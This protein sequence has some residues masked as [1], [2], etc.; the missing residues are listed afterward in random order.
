MRSLLVV[1]ALI[2]GCTARAHEAPV[3]TGSA[4]GSSIDEPRGATQ[5]PVVA[6]AKGELAAPASASAK[7]T[8]VAP[9]PP[10]DRAR[11]PWLD[12]ASLASD[13]PAV[14]GDTVATRFAPPD[15]FTR[16]PLADRSFGAWLRGLPLAPK[17]TP[18]KTFRGAVLHEADHENIAAVVAI[19]I[20]RSDLQQCADSVMRLH[21]EWMWSIGRRD[22]SYRAAS[23]AAMPYS[24]WAHGERIEQRGNNIAWVQG[25]TAHDDHAS[26]RAYLSAVFAWANTGALARDAHPIAKGEL[27]PGDFV[28]M[29]G[30][31]GHAVLVL[32]EAIDGKG[33]RALLLGQGYMPA[34][35]FQVLRPSRESLWFVLEPD[36][37]ALQTPFWQPFPLDLL[38]RLDVDKRD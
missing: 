9:Q 2:S 36:S 5:A 35:S 27:R 1:L 17:G 28:V 21:A 6:S 8:A 29:A 7:A 24:R 20:G 31:P 19:D 34:Q 38:R 37:E 32:D 11:Y 16:V 10:L 26:F 23:N 12:D 3:T 25:G 30:S 33:R 18:V 14:A 22:I 13:T 4:S 15:G